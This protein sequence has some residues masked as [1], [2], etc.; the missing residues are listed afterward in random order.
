VGEFYVRSSGIVPGE[1]PI[2]IGAGAI[3][4]VGGAAFGVKRGIEPIIVADFKPERLELARGS[5]PMCWWIPANDRPY[6]VWREVAANAGSRR[7]R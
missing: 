6:D 7:P 1:I 4:V 3:R 5:A 2:V